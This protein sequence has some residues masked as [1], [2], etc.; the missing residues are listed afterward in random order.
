[1]NSDGIISGGRSH[2]LSETPLR[3]FTFGFNNDF[4][5]KNFSLNVFFVGIHGF[6]L[7]NVNKAYAM[8]NQSDAREFNRQGLLESWRLRPR[9]RDT[10]QNPTVQSSRYVKMAVLSS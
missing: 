4:V 2:R 9:N 6:D 1:V 3:K 8:G 7:W 5:Y 10:Y